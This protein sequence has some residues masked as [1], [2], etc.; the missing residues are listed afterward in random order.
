MREPIAEQNE[1]TPCDDGL[2]PI[3]SVISVRSVMVSGASYWM[4]KA[5]Y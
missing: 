2:C 3:V 4:V 1:K 5:V